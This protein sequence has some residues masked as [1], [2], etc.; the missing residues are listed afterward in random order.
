VLAVGARAGGN[1]NDQPA[2]WVDVV[3]MVL[4]ALLVLLAAKRWR[5]RPRAGKEAALPKWMQTIDRFT[6]GRGRSASLPRCR[7]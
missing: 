2:T 1:E 5:E 3:K 6:P 4:G 7:E